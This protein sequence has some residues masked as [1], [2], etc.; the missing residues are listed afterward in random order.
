MDH[1]DLDRLYATLADNG[2]AHLYFER[3]GIAAAPIL[4]VTDDENADAIAGYLRPRIEGKTVVEIG[5]GLG[6]LSLHMG[7][8]AQRVF[9]IEANPI[10]SVL[11]T[12]VLFRTKPRNVSYLFGTADEFVGSIRGDVA[13]ICTHSDV[14]GMSLVAAQFAPTVI[15]VYGEIIGS[16]PGA[17]DPDVVAGR[18][19]KWG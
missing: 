2:S 10:W 19:A 1:A 11:F 16:A 12:E 15:D 7:L 6:L 18:E 5:G 13:V 8:I 3:H 14:P 9:C 17:F 4:T